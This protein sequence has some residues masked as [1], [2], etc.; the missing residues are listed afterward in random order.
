MFSKLATLCALVCTVSAQQPTQNIVEIAVGA[1]PEY[2]TLVAALTAADLVETLSGPGPFTVFAPTEAAF[3][4][5]P[6]G[7]VDNLLLPENKDDLVALLTYHVVSGTV[8]ST[9]LANGKVETLEGT[10]VTVDLTDGVKIND[11]TVTAADTEAT[12]G[13]IHQ[14]DTVLTTIPKTVVDVAL[15]AAPEFATLV[16]ALTAAELVDTLS[17]DGPFTV[18][19]PTEAAFAKLPAG[20]VDDLLLPA[21]KAQLIA[22]LKYHVVSGDVRSTDLANGN[23]ATIEG[24]SVAV[25]ITNGVMVND[26]AVTGADN[27]AVNG[28]VHIINTVLTY[29][30]PATVVDVAL[31][32]APEFATLVAALTAAELVDTLSG[33]GPFTV[34]APTEAAFAKLPDGAVAELLLP[35]NKDDLVALLTY[36]VVSGKVLSTDLTTGD[37]AT[38]EGNTVAVDITSGVMVN[39]ATVTGADNTAV[40]GVVH[41]I[42]RV[43]QAPIPTSAPTAGAAASTFSLTAAAAGIAMALRVAA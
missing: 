8:L 34:F 12:N 38:L 20:T 30:G 39:D 42:D 28:V 29:P 37:V 2:A 7:F 18:F 25:D 6:A 16:A 43:L 31:N 4:K 14:V 35:E 13:V 23:V 19:A 22:L 36:H 5:L 10:N 1:A 26:A 32:A 40:N 17:G 21:N 27:A 11:A 9:D 33:P 24:A 3:A 41:I 15:G